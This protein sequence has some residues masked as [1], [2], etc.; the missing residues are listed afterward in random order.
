MNDRKMLVSFFWMTIYIVCFL[1]FIADPDW[2]ESM[3]WV[4]FFAVIFA[5][6]PLVL[7]SD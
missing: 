4:M 7:H 5:T 6:I 2:R 3:R 1:I